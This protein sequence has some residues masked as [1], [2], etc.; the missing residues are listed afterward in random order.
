MIILCIEPVF[1]DQKIY[2]QYNKN[3]KQ[4]R[5]YRNCCHKSSAFILR[6]WIVNFCWLCAFRSSWWRNDNSLAI[7]WQQVFRS[8]YS[9]HKAIENSKRKFL[10]L[11][12]TLFLRQN[13]SI[14]IRNRISLL[15][16]ICA[17]R[18][19]Q[20]NNLNCNSILPSGTYWPILWVSSRKLWTHFD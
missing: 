14:L 19:T 20:N 18:N 2:R 6:E 17:C 8:W 5:Y 7:F 4:S 1:V 16:S 9:W 15:W 13:I 12:S 3:Q 10:I 11:I